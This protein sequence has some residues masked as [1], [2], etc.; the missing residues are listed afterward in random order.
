[1]PYVKGDNAIQNAIVMEEGCTEHDN[2]Q[3]VF[4]SEFCFTDQS[5]G[6]DTLVCT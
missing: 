3:L 4:S 5:R 2:T 6:P 1:M